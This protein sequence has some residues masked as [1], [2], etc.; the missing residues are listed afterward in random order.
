MSQPWYRFILKLGTYASLASLF[1]LN[2]HFYFPYITSKQLYF[3]ILIEVLA[4]VWLA[5][6][7]KY[8]ADRPKKSW[9][10]RGWLAYLAVVLLT[11]FTGIDFNLS[12]WGDL[13]RMLGWF[14]LFHFFLLYLIAITAFR[15]WR[16]WQPL[17][18]TM[19]GAGVLLSLIGVFQN[20]NAS[21][22][23]NAA[24]MGT[25]TLMA[26]FIIIFLIGR[27]RNWL[28]ALPYWF[29]LAILAIGFVRADISGAYAGLAA[30]L[31]CYGVTMS[32]LSRSKKVRRWGW[33]SIGAFVA[34]VGLI[35]SLRWSETFNNSQLGKVFRDFSLSNPTLNTRLLSWQYAWK[36]FPEHW[37]LGTGYGNYSLVFDR[38]FTGK[39][40]DFGKG[41]DYFD[42]AHNNIVEIATTTGSLGLLAYLF[43]FVWAMIYL[44]KAYQHKKLE[45]PE[46]AAMFSLMIAYFVQNLALFDCLASYLYFMLILAFINN[47]YRQPTTVRQ[48]NSGWEGKEMIV[49]VVGGLAALWVIWLTNVSTIKMLGKTIDGI[50]AVNQ[51]QAYQALA[52]FKEA[53]AAQSPLVRDGRSAMINAYIGGSY[54]LEQLPGSQLTEII[55]YVD[56]QS[57]KNIN[58]NP[59]DSYLNMQRAQFLSLASQVSRNNLSAGYAKDG[60]KAA[61]QAIENGYDHVLPHYVKAQLLSDLDQPDEAIAELK[62]T[63]KISEKYW[64]TF[65]HLSRMQLNRGVDKEEAYSH[66]DRCLEEGGARLLGAGNYFNEAIKYYQDKKDTIK[67][68]MLTEQLARI[69]P[70]GAEVWLRLA[71]LYQEQGILDGAYQAAQQAVQLKPELKDSLKEILLID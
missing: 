27:S 62:A 59:K 34:I 13:E 55:S 19:S 18:I 32:L 28:L 56:Q 16:D 25:I 67:L 71:Q 33:F 6:L 53:E 26:I 64:D 11:C 52:L 36:D 60:L 63:L 17:L 43:M 49:F 54:Y 57:T 47:A 10:T 66:L 38:Q 4:V 12:F 61:E 15:N 23:G 48:E 69:Y 68:I 21:M 39:F 58:Y 2:K 31:V 41:E 37:L 24:Y 35:F 14:P 46:F 70:Q 65:C 8:P 5:Y 29:A 7:W 22:L 51:G 1:L 3:N 20:Y 42:R 9:I 30:G 45:L 40:Y 50:I 44:I